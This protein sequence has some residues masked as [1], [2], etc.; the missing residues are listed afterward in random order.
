MNIIFDTSPLKTGHSHRGIGMYTSLLLRELKQLPN[1]QIFE[2]LH[3][4][5]NSKIELIHYPYFDLFFHTLPIIKPVPR[6]VVTIHDVIPLEFKDQYPVGKKGT[7]AFYAQR[8]ALANTTAVLTDSLSSRHSIQQY[9]KVPEKKITTTYLAAN[10]ALKVQP[11]ESVSELI[12]KYQL[13]K[14][15]LL[16]VGDINYNKNIPQLIK[17]LKFLDDELELVLFGK[18]F[19][20]QDIPEWHWI[21]TQL[22]LS[23]VAARVR[24]L[25]SVEDDKELSALYSGAAVYVQPSLAE[26]FGL[27][28]LEA[29]QCKT[30]VVSSNATSLPEVGGTHVQ[31]A[32]PVAE[33]LAAAVRTQLELT[34]TERENRLNEGYNWARS[35]TW[36]KTAEATYQVYQS[37]I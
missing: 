13:P 5:K 21:E 8:L 15:Y 6:S 4:A 22:A 18:N 16:Y 31:Y 33:S 28:V 27:P 26:G 11:P 3:Q 37:I 17:S 35:F 12:K 25:S 34:P 23:D 30:L 14:K 10:P 9:L 1:L 2:S 24:F 29:L 7:V 20:P 19:T 36:K 32:D